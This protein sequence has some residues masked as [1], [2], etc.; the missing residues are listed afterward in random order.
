V[1]GVSAAGVPYAAPISSHRH[2]GSNL[3]A[4]GQ[5]S[6]NQPKPDEDVRSLYLAPRNGGTLDVLVVVDIGTRMARVAGRLMSILPGSKA[7]LRIGMD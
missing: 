4:D 1:L 3:S 7:K 5:L 2:F 6:L